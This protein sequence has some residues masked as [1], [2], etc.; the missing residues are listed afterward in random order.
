MNESYVDVYTK[1]EV[2]FLSIFSISLIIIAVPANFLVLAGYVTSRPI[3]TKSSSILL[4]SLTVADLFAS[5]L[6]IPFQ[7]VFQVLH[8]SMAANRGPLCSFVGSVTYSF[9]IVITQTLVCMS[10]DRFYAIR[11]ALRYQS[12]MTRKRVAVMIVFTWLHSIIFVLL[13]GPFAVE[14]DYNPRLGICGIIF[15][16]RMAKLILMALVYIII[17][18]VIMVIFNCKMALYLR[19]HNRRMMTTGG[20]HP[21]Y[22]RNGRTKTREGE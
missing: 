22:E 1:D 7:L 5:A 19:R 8:P 4:A 18:F 2:T 3:R 15:D 17:P 13:L 6:V 20:I 11:F 16:D 10:V 9:Y 14:V 12:I 21:I